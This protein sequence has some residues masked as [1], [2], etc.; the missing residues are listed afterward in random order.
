MGRTSIFI[1]GRNPMLFPGGLEA[2]VR[3]Y[4]RAAMRAGY[5]PHHFCVGKSARLEA[6]PFG[7]LHLAKRPSARCAEFSS[8]RR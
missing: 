4:G 5:E 6:T 1:G 8:P 2:F 3:A 7:A